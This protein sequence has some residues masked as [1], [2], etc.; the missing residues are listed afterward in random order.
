[1]KRNNKRDTLLTGRLQRYL[2]HTPHC[3]R[4][5]QIERSLF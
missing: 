3:V 5:D 1:M 4:M 2:G